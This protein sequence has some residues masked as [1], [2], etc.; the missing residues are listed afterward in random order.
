MKLTNYI[1]DAF[2]RSAMNDVPEV[3]YEEQIRSAGTK[4]VLDVLPADV[5][6]AY[7]DEKQRPYVNT[8]YRK[9][10]GV[11]MSVPGHGGCWSGEVAYPVLPA[12]AI[13]HLDELQMKHQ[14][15]Q[16]QRSELE[17]KLKAAAYAC[18]TRKA[19]AE[20]LPEF[21]KYLPADEAKAQKVMLPAVANIVADFTKAG[22]PKGSKR[23]IAAA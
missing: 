10:G 17:S 19:L 23:A 2:V 14:E 15:Q 6:K 16:K 12:K 20:L 8:H 3:D 9:L 21:E 18:T 7:D 22:W 1:R 11:S 4:A 13:K 5:R